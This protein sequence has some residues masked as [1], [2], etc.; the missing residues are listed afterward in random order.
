M[1][2]QVT[3]VEIVHGLVD[4][5]LHVVWAVH[6]GDKVEVYVEMDVQQ[7]SNVGSNGS[8]YFKVQVLM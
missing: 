2:S 3:F 6:V 4:K 8:M 7:D 1:A 5:L